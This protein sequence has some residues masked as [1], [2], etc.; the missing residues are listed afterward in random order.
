MCS[1]LPSI[2]HSNIIN[3]DLIESLASIIFIYQ[4]PFNITLIRIV[5]LLITRISV[6]KTCRPKIKT[7]QEKLYNNNSLYTYITS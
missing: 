4:F 1:A 7:L 6:I 3:L 2:N 5:F